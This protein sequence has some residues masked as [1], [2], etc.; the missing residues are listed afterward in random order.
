MSF[1]AGGRGMGMGPGGP[2]PG[3]TG[4]MG[5]GGG[6]PSGDETYLEA[7]VESVAGLPHEVR[8]NLDLLRDLDA[9]CGA[10]TDRL[11]R[12]QN[13]YVAQAERRMMD[14]EIVVKRQKN[15]ADHHQQQQP[16]NDSLPSSSMS[17][18]ARQ[19][20]KDGDG[21]YFVGV[22]VL[23]GSG[24]V[25]IPTTMELEQYVFHD[26]NSSSSTSSSPHPYDRILDLQRDLVQQSDE[27]VAVA[28][29]VHDRLDAT[30]RR[31][32]K[33][34]AEMEMLLQVCVCACDRCFANGLNNLSRYCCLVLLI[35]LS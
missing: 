16:P 20:D 18:P 4:M 11:L 10:G 25:V 33:D 7:F 23:G 19:G 14:V 8:R 6:G 31:L 13:E 30:V 3:G 15:Q 12:L 34:L 29:Q 17:V 27:K 22:R 1:S 9:K 35:A 5:I 28:R 32:D 24:D 2:G 21:S 26:P